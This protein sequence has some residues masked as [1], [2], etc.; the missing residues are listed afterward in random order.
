MSRLLRQNT[1]H[2]K[3]N[4]GKYSECTGDLRNH[5]N[6]SKWKYCRKCFTSV[7][8]LSVSERAH[9]GEEPYECRECGKCFSQALQL[10]KHQR[11]HTGEKPYECEH[12]GKVF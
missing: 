7:G 1:G 11:I 3:R 12:C 5:V 10:S 4:C 6:G 2:S 9:A 8:K